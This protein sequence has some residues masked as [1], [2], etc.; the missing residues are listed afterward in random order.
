MAL[1]TRGIKFQAKKEVSFGVAPTFT[2]DDT[3][4]IEKADINTKIDTVDRK[5]MSDTIVKQAGIP[6]RF[7]T[8]GN[9][10]LEMDVKVGTNK[11]AGSVLYEAGLGGVLENGAEIDSTNK[12]INVK[13][14]GS[15]DATLYRITDITESIA[16]RKF[17]DSG[18]VVLQS[19]G[20]V[21]NKV[22]L[23]FSQANILTAEF[24]IEGATFQTMSG[25]SLPDCGGCN[26]IPFVGKNAIFDFYGNSVSA[27]NIKVD[28]SNKV[29][30]E[31]AIN[32]DGY[33]GKVIVEK[34]IKG[35]FTCMLENFDYLDK[36]KAQT[37]GSLYLEIPNSSTGGT[38]ALYIPRLKITDAP[39]T[40]DAGS[41]IEVKV[42]FM[43]ETDSTTGESL[44]LATKG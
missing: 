39:V 14:D 34:E 1:K 18:D 38:I 36:L 27:K 26:S 43:A 31:E 44:L 15:G 3:I 32:T 9:V 40:D 35:E 25:L 8:D 10:S 42:D 7:T 5:C 21:I 13:S 6:V 23:D 19:L 41:L 2:N 33:T 37:E 20:C 30:N 11:F 24:G 28:I 29:T 17:F 22:S 12:K 16:I 4:C